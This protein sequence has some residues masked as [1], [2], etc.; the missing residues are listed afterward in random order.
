[1]RVVS[2]AAFDVRLD[3]FD[4]QALV[5]LTSSASQRLIV[6]APAC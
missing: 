4:E 6:L 5:E 2:R 1:M 3:A